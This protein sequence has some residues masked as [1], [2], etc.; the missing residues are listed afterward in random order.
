MVNYCYKRYDSRQSP[1]GP[2]SSERTRVGLNNNNYKTNIYTG[3][4][5]QQVKTA[6]IKVCY[7]PYALTFTTKNVFSHK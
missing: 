6:V 7:V 3:Y 4:T 2:K 1:V 5:L